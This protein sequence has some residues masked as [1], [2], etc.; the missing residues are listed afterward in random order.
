MAWEFIRCAVSE[1]LCNGN[2]ILKSKT[3]TGWCH[4]GRKSKTNHIQT[5][6]RRLWASTGTLKVGIFMSFTERSSSANQRL[7]SFFET[8]AVFW[9][10]ERDVRLSSSVLAHSWSIRLTLNSFKEIRLAHIQMHISSKTHSMSGP[11]RSAQE[12]GE[13]VVRED[14]VMYK[15][16]ERRKRDREEEW[17]RKAEV[18]DKQV[19]ALLYEFS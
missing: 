19:L 12:H 16:A 6:L 3:F 17:E 14:S 4:K 5:F 18:K 1:L 11:R 13:M 8:W 15:S 2:N 9:H 10:A 7:A